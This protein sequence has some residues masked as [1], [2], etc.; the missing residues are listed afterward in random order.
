MGWSK[1]C[2]SHTWSWI[3]SFLFCC[4]LSSYSI[5]QQLTKWSRDFSFR[6]WRLVV[7]YL[8]RGP[9]YS[10]SL[11]RSVF[12][13]CMKLSALEKIFRL[14]VSPLPFFF[15]DDYLTQSQ[16][17]NLYN[18]RRWVISIWQ[19]DRKEK[20]HLFCWFF[21][22]LYALL[23]WHKSHC[24]IIAYLLDWQSSLIYSNLCEGGTVSVYFII[25]F[26]ESKCYLACIGPL[27]FVE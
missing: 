17:F 27:I 23:S 15:S 12:W 24:I 14:F 10:F 8:T 5:F 18:S 16:L 7:E 4:H 2:F 21:W 19:I 11:P 13:L 6:E 1:L 9:C 26:P 20:R 25:T 3:T 22:G